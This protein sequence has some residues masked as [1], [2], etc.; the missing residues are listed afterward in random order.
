MNFP[1]AYL[2]HLVVLRGLGPGDAA[3]RVFDLVWVTATAVAIAAFV[4]PWGAVAAAGSALLFAT[5]TWPVERG[6]R[7]SATSCFACFS[8]WARSAWRGGSRNGRGGV[9]S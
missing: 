9:S 4:A 5:Y 8:F 6:W 2:L 7:A 1:G 3:W